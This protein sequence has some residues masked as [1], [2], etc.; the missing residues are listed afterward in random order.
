MRSTNINYIASL[1][2]LRFLAAMLIV[3]F[4]LA[5]GNFV[6]YMHLDIGV[7]LFFTLSGY[8]FFTIADNRKDS[9][10]LY[11]K[12][13]YNRILRIYPL[14][15]LL[16]LMTVVLID[17]FNALDFNNLFGLNLPG[18]PRESWIIGDWGYKYLSFNWWTVVV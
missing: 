3:I 9:E 17:N 1:D 15:T 13:L 16:F 18:A 10:I 14:I 8:L 11:W 12:F 2:H 4:H 5:N 7:P 6:H